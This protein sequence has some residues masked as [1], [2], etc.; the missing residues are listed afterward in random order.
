ML[1]LQGLISPPPP[2]K[3]KIYD[4]MCNWPCCGKMYSRHLFLYGGLIQT[5]ILIAAELSSKGK[6]SSFHS[7]II[8][9]LGSV[10]ENFGV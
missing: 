4:F 3:K 7:I 5:P 8:Y 1:L 9:A 6:Q 10:Q 2:K